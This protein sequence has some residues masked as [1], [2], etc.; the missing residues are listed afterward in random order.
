MKILSTGG[1]PGPLEARIAAC[2]TFVGAHRNETP[3]DSTGEED[4]EDEDVPLHGMYYI[5][6][7]IGLQD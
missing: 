5:R 4:H 7:I 6:S 3:P 1:Q 2:S